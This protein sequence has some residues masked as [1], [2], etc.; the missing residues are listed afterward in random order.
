MSRT[1]P[2]PWSVGRVRVRVHSGPREDGRWRWRADRP[3][4]RGGRVPVWSGWGSRDEAEAAILATLAGDEPAADDDTVRTVGDLMDVWLGAQEERSDIAQSTIR[5]RRSHVRHLVR[6][7]SALRDVLLTR[8]DRRTLERYRDA[9]LR[10]GRAPSTLREDLRHL[11]QAWRWGRE[12]GVC[13]DTELPAVA[14]RDR[15]TVYS[16]RTPT[17]AEVLAVLD[18]LRGRVPWAWRATY[19]TWATGC[20]KGEIAGLL[21]ER[22]DLEA[23]TAEVRGK[24]GGRVVPLRSEVVDELRRWPRER[25]TVHGR[26]AGT[27]IG[28]LHREVTEACDRVGIERFPPH[29]LR[30]AA[31]DALYRT[32]RPEVAA[33]ILGHSPT[34]A[35]R[36]Y[37]QVRAEE[38]AEA[39]ES[40]ALGVVPG[41]AVLAFTKE[42]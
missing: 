17:R 12:V 13:P 32:T 18:D 4:G 23:G 20:R 14:V 7:E 3:D 42:D 34:T 30:R 28:Q 25:E 5:S 33:A 22:I 29:G 9:E 21:W 27:V 1:R 41:G 11:R 10:G 38:L 37:R 39:I 6:R 36:H 19:L 2:K 26:A 24:T 8:C 15:S 16:R 35:L 31:V 40:T